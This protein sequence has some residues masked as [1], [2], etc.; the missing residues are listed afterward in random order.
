MRCSVFACCLEIVGENWP[1]FEWFQAQ[2]P[3]E[4]RRGIDGTAA[5]LLNSN[6]YSISGE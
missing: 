5:D 2:P 1:S 6:W 3:L 4:S